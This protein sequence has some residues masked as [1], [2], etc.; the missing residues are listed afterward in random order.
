MVLASPGLKLREGDELTLRTFR[1]F[2]ATVRLLLEAGVTTVAEAA[3]QDHVW[4]PQ[5][6]P[7]MELA[8]VRVVQCISDEIVAHKRIGLR[9][10]ADPTRKA[11]SEAEAHRLL[12]PNFVRLALDVPTLVVDTDGRDTSR[13][14]RPSPHSRP[15]TP[16]S[17]SSFLDAVTCV[18]L[19]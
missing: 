1:T 3:F 7:L 17:L 5:L 12:G 9:A 13:N 15:P 18:R 11:H 10:A 4:R 2:F 8:D 14:W 16:T 19:A 6:E